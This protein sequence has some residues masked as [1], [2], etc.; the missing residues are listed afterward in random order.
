MGL[1]T[2]PDSRTIKIHAAVSHHVEAETS[3]RNSLKGEEDH[4]FIVDEDEVGVVFSTI[5]QA[6]VTKI[7]TIVVMKADLVPEIVTIEEVTVVK[8]MIL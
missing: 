8:M 1:I 3:T 7:I 6:Q 5:N 2:V 4:L